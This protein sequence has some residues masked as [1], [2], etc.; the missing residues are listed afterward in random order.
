LRKERFICALACGKPHANALLLP[1]EP[2]ISSSE[3]IKYK[4]EPRNARFL[5]VSLK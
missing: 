2:E 4:K 3:S 1:V 5:A